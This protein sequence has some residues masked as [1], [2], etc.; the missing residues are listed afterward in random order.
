MVRTLVKFDPSLL[1][2]ITCVT[3]AGE[4][5]WSGSRVMAT[6]TTYPFDLGQVFNARYVRITTAA[7]P[8]WVAWGE[9]AVFR[10]D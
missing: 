3:L 9:V 5:A 4:G 2:E 8:S 1:T 7:S 10:C 6:G